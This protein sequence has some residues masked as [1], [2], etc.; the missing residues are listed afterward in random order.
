MRKY[1]ILS[2]I[3][4]L[5]AVFTYAHAETGSSGYWFFNGLNLNNNKYPTLE[6]VTTDIVAFHNAHPGAYPREAEPLAPIYPPSL[7]QGIQGTVRWKMITFEP[8]KKYDQ[9]AFANYQMCPVGQIY[10]E[11]TNKCQSEPPPPKCTPGEIVSSGLY[12][13]GPIA[14]SSVPQGI[15]HRGCYVNFT[16]DSPV[17]RALVG[18]KYHYY[19]RGHYEKVGDSCS[20]PGDAPAGLGNTPTPTCGSGQTLT[21]GTGKPSCINTPGTGGG[22]P[23]PANPHT[24]DAPKPPEETKEEKHPP[25]TNPDGSTS[26]TTT[27][28]YPDGSTKNETTTTKTDGSTSTTITTTPAAIDPT[29]TPDPMKDFCSINP[30]NKLCKD[31][32]ERSWGRP[33]GVG[34]EFDI[35]TKDEEIEAKKDEFKQLLQQIRGEV[36]GLFNWSGAGGAGQLGC[37]GSVNILGANFQICLGQYSEQLSLIADG[38]VFLSLLLALFIILA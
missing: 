15:C 26:Q 8:G 35:P 12:D 9:Q 37:S 17:A 6:S 33:D 7:A 13:I 11:S 23:T 28:T 32:D 38:L 34:K 31:T 27:T 18:G 5:S 16:G 4:L 30:N 29:K 3:F 10:Y 24:P 2:F 19:A 21:F 22:T 25:T 20:V 36:Q 1:L 14:T